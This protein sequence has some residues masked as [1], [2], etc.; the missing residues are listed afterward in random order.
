MNKNKAKHENRQIL[1]DVDSL[2]FLETAHKMLIAVM[3]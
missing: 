1:W 3:M 2:L